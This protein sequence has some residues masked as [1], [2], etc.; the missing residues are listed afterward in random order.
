MAPR[1]LLGVEMIVQLVGEN[2]NSNSDH[3]KEAKEIEG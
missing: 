1:N 3:N 2:S